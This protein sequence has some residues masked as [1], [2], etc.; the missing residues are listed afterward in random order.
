MLA[1][2]KE[3][4]VQVLACVTDFLPFP[5]LP[6]HSPIYPSPLF[7]FYFFPEVG[8]TGPRI[9]TGGAGMKRGSQ[10]ETKSAAYEK[11]L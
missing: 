5:V 8:E 1:A 9:R 11:F 6:G 10:R 3:K 2:L 7:D 4:C